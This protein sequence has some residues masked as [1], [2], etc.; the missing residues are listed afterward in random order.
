MGCGRGLWV[1]YLVGRWTQEAR[2]G[3]RREWIMEREKR[4]ESGGYFGKNNLLCH[5][6]IDRHSTVSIEDGQ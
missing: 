6:V 5:P 2:C 1:G 3:P 4:G